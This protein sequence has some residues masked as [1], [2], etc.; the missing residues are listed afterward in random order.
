MSRLV[1]RQAK[2]G[3]LALLDEFMLPAGEPGLI[4]ERVNYD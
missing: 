2:C 1:P 4:G 3:V